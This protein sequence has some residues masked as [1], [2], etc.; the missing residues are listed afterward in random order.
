MSNKKAEKKDEK[1]VA[2]TAPVV[3]EETAAVAPGGDVELVVGDPQLL[4]P[5]ELPLV[6]RPAEGKEWK[7]AE[8]AEYAAVLNGYAYRNPKKWAAKKDA[9]IKTLH[10]IGSNPEAIIK[11]RGNVSGVS[12]K[13][14]LISQ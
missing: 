10:E 2:S 6:V 7:N 12:F 3:A 13:N 1:E 14:K 8:Q 9:L 4:R 5:I 11:V